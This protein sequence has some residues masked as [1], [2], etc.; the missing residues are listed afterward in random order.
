[1]TTD[2]VV[3]I[4]SC[5]KA[6]TGTAAMQLVEEGRLDLDAPGQELCPGVGRGQG[7]RGV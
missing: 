1:M 7:D 6:I 5:T 2:T 3:C 4:F